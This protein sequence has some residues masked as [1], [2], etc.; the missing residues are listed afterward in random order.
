LAASGR[1]HAPPA[2]AA[3]DR[4]R[5]RFLTRSPSARRACSRTREA[6]GTGIPC[7]SNKALRYFSAICWQWKQS[8]SGTAGFAP[9]NRPAAA[10][11]A[12]A[13][14]THSAV[15]FFIQH[16]APGKHVAPEGVAESQSRIEFL[17]WTHQQVQ[18][19]GVFYPKANPARL[20]HR[21]RGGH[22]HQDVHIALRGGPAV[23]VRTEQNDPIRIKSLDDLSRH[24][25][26]CRTE[27]R[28][29][30][31]RFDRRGPGRA[32]TCHPD[33][34][35]LRR[36]TLSIQHCHPR[37]HTVQPESPRWDCASLV[38]PCAARPTLHNSATG[39]SRPLVSVRTAR[40]IR[41]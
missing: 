32:R 31:R 11:S 3:D 9:A 2:V 12:S 29:S 23:S 41:S 19:K 16:L 36:S 22:H 30:A 27:R 10:K 24:P 28:E 34:V 4:T 39:F 25:A 14:R 40:T 21:I 13:F 1:P 6:F 8:G 33:L 37:T 26:N 38:P 15:N 18:R 35:V 5:Q 7:S 20:A 17:L